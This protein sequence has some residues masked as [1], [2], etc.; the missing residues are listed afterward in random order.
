[1]LLE[2]QKGLI[3]MEK[4]PN[5]YVI[6]VESGAEMARLIDQ[7]R[8]LT[9]CMGGLF[10]ELPEL[11]KVRRTLD[12]ACGPGGWAQEMAYTYPD[13]RVVGVDI[14]QRMIGYAETLSQVQGLDNVE[15]WVMDLLKPLDFPDA[16]FDLINARFLFGVLRA[17]SWLPLMKELMRVLR[18]GGVLRCTECDGRF[19]TNSPAFERYTDVA[20]QA[21]FL[22]GRSLNGSTHYLGITPMLGRFLQMVGCQNIQ[23]KV[24]VLNWSAGMEAYPSVCE[25]VRVGFKLIQPFLLK[26]QVA[27]EEEI[28]QLY[29]QT[30]AE[31]LSDDFRALWY[32]LSVWGQKPA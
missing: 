23:E 18:P 28:E 14:S 26:M 9:K 15:F 12:A 25:D 7:D 32:F 11:E 19:A 30:L 4:A 24:H 5:S 13:M 10:P 2:E 29:K 31:C 3:I 20:M 1:M 8:F 6:N 21:F 22:D 17:D 27:G 16:S